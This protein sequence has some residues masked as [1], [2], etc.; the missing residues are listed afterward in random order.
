[1]IFVIISGLFNFFVC[2]FLDLEQKLTL[3]SFF[4]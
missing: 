4:F 1:M 3:L 2:R